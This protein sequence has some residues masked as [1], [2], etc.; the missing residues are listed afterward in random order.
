MNL[1]NSSFQMEYNVHPRPTDSVMDV[2]EALKSAHPPD[3]SPHLCALL[4]I[5]TFI[6]TLT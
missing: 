3:P 6:L 1:L 4:C 5:N 2:M